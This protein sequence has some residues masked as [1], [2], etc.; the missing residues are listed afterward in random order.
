MRYI[1][2]T[3]LAAFTIGFLVSLFDV[4]AQ[5]TRRKRA[6]KPVVASLPTPANAEP[7]VISRADDNPADTPVIS[8]ALEN[9][10]RISDE[11]DPDAHERKIAELSE[12]IKNLEG[13][14]TDDYETRQKRIAMNLEILTKAEQRAESLR[15]QSFDLFEKENTIK[16]RLDEID[17][18][19]RPEMIDRSIAFVGSLRPED[20]RASRRKNLEAEKANLQSVLAEIQRNR[21]NLEGTLQRADQLVEK[22]RVRVEADIDAA[23]EPAKPGEKP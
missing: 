2:K 3:V 14:K 4:N 8:P 10:I 12:R 11:Q 15:K 22:L 1:L 20:L 16:T 21:S 5:T 7:V 18:Q 23:L 9:A 6:A 13:K 19:L 17:T